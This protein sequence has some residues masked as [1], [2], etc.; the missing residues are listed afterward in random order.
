MPLCFEW[1]NMTKSG[2]RHHF[3]CAKK[4]KKSF[5]KKEK[6]VDKRYRMIYNI[7]INKIKELEKKCWN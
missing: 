3:L 2:A 7:I 4:Y 5:S 1:D 6:I